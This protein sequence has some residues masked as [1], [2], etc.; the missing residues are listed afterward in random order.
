MKANIIHK[1]NFDKNGIYEEKF[2]YNGQEITST[3]FIGLESDLKDVED[4]NFEDERNCAECCGCDCKENELEDMIHNTVVDIC[5]TD[6]CPWCIE[7]KLR[8]FMS[9]VLN[10]IDE[11]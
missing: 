10:Y 7:D 6:G 8:T 4:F 5:N 9:D 1:I 11:E 2:L 3:Q